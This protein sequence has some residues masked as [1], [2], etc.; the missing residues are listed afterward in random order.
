VIAIIA[1][2]IALLLPAVQA[3]REAARRAQ[4][5]NNLKQLGLAIHNYHSTN[6]VVPADGMFLGP[7]WGSCCPPS[8]GGT[9]WGWNASW[10][11]TLLPNM[12]QNSLYNAY[13]FKDGADQPTNY[14][15]GFSLIASL[16]CPSDNI[17]IRPASPWA[18]TSYHGNHGGPGHIQNW[19]G[20]ITQNFTSYPQAWWGADGNMA[21]FGFESMTDGTSNTAMLSEKLIGVAN[22]PTVYVGTANAKR[23]IF[24]ATYSGSYD[25][26][27]NGGALAIAAIGACK[28]I[29]G[30]Q[31]SVGSYLS[32]A[33][34]SLAYPWHHSNTSYRHHNTPNAL[35]CITASDPV[36]GSN[37]WGGVV[38]M[39]TA[40][41]NHPGGVNVCFGDGSVKFVKDTIAP[42]TWWALGTISGEE[43][44]SA[45]AY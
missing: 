42:L 31:G 4:C 35:S 45:D 23:G 44:I 25:Q 24:L 38:D 41:S 39:I 36:G 17:K 19:S 21:F 33:H 26:G 32:G 12:E 16:V 29:P 15:V 9:G 18:P 3:A 5:V 10:M 37:P 40:T 20:A 28:S 6:N 7:A 14:T 8:N 13:N 27:R 1:V 2:L 43:V 22:N 34:W 30:T 11:V